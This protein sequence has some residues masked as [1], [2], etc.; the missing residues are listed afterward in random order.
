MIPREAVERTAALAEGY[1]AAFLVGAAFAALAA[2]VGGAL[3]R[4]RDAL[5]SPH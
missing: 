3:L 1:R 4:T 5:G 2:V